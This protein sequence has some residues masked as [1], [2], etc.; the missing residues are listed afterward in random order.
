MAVV[1]ILEM[2]RVRAKFL[3]IVGELDI[4]PSW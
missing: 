3:D 2:Q 4:A 1:C